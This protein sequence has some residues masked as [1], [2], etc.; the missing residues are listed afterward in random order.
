[1]TR[2]VTLPE[3]WR[4]LAEEAGGV[5]ELAKLFRVSPKTLYNWA[6]GKSAVSG[7]AQIQLERLKKKFAVKNLKK[8]SSPQL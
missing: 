3:P 6:H 2:R 5:G 4:S 7:P 8:I 1:M